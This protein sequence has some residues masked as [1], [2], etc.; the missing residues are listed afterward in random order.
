MTKLEG[1]MAGL[2]YFDLLSREGVVRH[3][4]WMREVLL[5]EEV[6]LM[7]RIMTQEVYDPGNV[8]AVGM[9]RVAEGWMRVVLGTVWAARMGVGG[10]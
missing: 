6:G 9:G 7:D 4:G 8:V 1:V 10:G 5:A 3:W 2:D